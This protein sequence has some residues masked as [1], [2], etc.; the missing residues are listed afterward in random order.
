MNFLK[1]LAAVIVLSAAAQYFFPW[2]TVAIACFIVGFTM[3]RSGWGAFGVGFLGIV[4]LWSGLAFYIDSATGS[5]L[6]ER[7]A[8]IILLP[9]GDVLKLVVGLIGGLVGG[10]S[11]L[12]GFSMKSIR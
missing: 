2:W 4:L 10:F 6:S 3:S 11:A 1:Q 5:N 8:K 7:V 9:S 12:S